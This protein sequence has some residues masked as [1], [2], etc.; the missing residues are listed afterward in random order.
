MKIELWDWKIGCLLYILGDLDPAGGSSTPFVGISRLSEGLLVTASGGG[1]LR[2]GTADNWSS[3]TLIQHGS[4]LLSILGG[5]DSDFVTADANGDVTFWRNGAPVGAV[6][7]CNAAL[8]GI[9][10]SVGETLAVIG[11]ASNMLVFR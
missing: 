8:L 2:I 1:A 7:G 3:S 10:A 11:A 5:D 9:L 6:A 4:E